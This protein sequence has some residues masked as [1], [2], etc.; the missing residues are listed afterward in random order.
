MAFPSAAHPM[1]RS[2]PALRA[3]TLNAAIAPPSGAPLSIPDPIDLFGADYNQCYGN[4]SAMYPSIPEGSL[5]PSTDATSTLSRKAPSPASIASVPL[6]PTKITSCHTR[7]GRKAIANT[8]MSSPRHVI[9]AAASIAASLASSDVVP[10]ILPTINPN[11][12]DDVVPSPLDGLLDPPPAAD[13]KKKKE[14]RRIMLGCI[15]KTQFLSFCRPIHHRSKTSYSEKKIQSDLRGKRRSIMFHFHAPNQSNSADTTEDVTGPILRSAVEDF[16]DWV[17]D[18][19]SYEMNKTKERT[20]SRYAMEQLWIQHDKTKLLLLVK[21]D[22]DE[23]MFGGKAAAVDAI[24]NI[25]RTTISGKKYYRLKCTI[26]DG[27]RNQLVHGIAAKQYTHERFEYD[28]KH[29]H[30]NFGI[31]FD[32]TNEQHKFLWNTIMD[33]PST[34]MFFGPPLTQ[35]R[36]FD[37]IFKNPKSISTLHHL[38]ISYYAEFEGDVQACLIYVVRYWKIV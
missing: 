10:P 35:C 5:P 14:S 7:R 19:D 33:F 2:P 28:Y 11:D 31:S 27:N 1:D 23:E 32:G 8:A 29:R 30:G 15:P 20:L 25:K 12:R 17:V 13:K 6:S 18:H 37:T 36:A 3:T 9:V 24:Q 21:V 34:F 22:D 26:T 16:D 4:L 38:F